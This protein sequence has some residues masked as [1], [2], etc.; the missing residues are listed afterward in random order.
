[1]VKNQNNEIWLVC[2]NPRCQV[3]SDKIKLS[4]LMPVGLAI[5]ELRR[6][7]WWIGAQNCHWCPI[8]SPLRGRVQRAN[9]HFNRGRMH[10]RGGIRRAFGR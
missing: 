4:F 5:D 10:Q 9:H 1:M 8:C 6:R 7:G 3:E 2:N